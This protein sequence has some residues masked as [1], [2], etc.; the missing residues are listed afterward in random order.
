MRMVTSILDHV[1][2]SYMDIPLAPSWQKLYQAESA[3][4]YVSPLKARVAH[5]YLHGVIYPPAQQIFT[6]LNLCPLE[7][8]CVVIL[9]QDPYHSE[10]QAHG[11]AFSVPDG[12]PI[13]PSLRNIYKEIGSDIG[14]KAPTSGN[15]ERWAEQGVLLL[16]TTLTVATGAPGSHAGW[17]WEHFTDAIIKTVSTER[18]HVV[19]LLWGTHAKAKIDFIDRSKHLVLTAPHPSPLSAHRGFFG[20]RHFSKTNEY[21]KQHGLKPIDW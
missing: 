9:G 14:I 11:L 6:A 16:N 20:C 13:P 17:G 4:P 3:K 10:G 7:E 8:V 1:Y 21:L 15:L 19:F 2:Y 12:I 18:E 5:S